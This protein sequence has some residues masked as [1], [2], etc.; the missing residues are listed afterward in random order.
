MAFQSIGEAMI[1]VPPQEDVR[2]AEAAHQPPDLRNDEADPA[3]RR[4][5]FI[6]LLSHSVHV[7]TPDPVLPRPTCACAA[8]EG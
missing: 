3:R 8:D 4:I 5:G 6:V 2:P 7:P 1:R